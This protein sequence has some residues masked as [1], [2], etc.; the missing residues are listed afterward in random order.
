MKEQPGGSPVFDIPDSWIY[1]K[2]AGFV[3]ISIKFTKNI[4]TRLIKNF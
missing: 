1:G 2:G 3:F 4:R